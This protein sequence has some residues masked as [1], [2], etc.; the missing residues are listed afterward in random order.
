MKKDLKE[1]QG[2]IK[3]DYTWTTLGQ[4]LDHLVQ[5]GVSTNVA[6]FVSAV[7]VTRTFFLIWSKRRPDM[8]EISI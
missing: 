4:Y 6:S 5:R 7:F 3:F 2:D 8:K 1:R